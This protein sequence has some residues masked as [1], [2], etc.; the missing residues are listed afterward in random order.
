V[1]ASCAE[2]CL[3][4][5][6]ASQARAR[7]TGAARIIAFVP[8]RPAIL[9][10]GALLALAAAGCGA[11]DREA[12]AATVAERFHAALEQ[13]DGRAACAELSEETASKLEQQEEATCEEAV[14]ELELPRGG[15][16]AE[17]SVYVT[18]AFV[19]LVEGGTTF[20]DEGADGWKVSAAGC[21]PTAPNLPYDCELEG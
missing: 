5:H 4:G 20:L 9:M 10:L 6:V 12:D 15:A 18:S 19:D 17:T 7:P 21:T 16:A 2:P 3:P 8:V 11:Y 13:R 14:L 1:P